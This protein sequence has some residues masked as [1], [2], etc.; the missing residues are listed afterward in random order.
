[1]DV[2]MFWFAMTSSL[3]S[4]STTDSI[5]LMFVGIGLICTPLAVLIYTRINTQRDAYE[6]SLATD[7]EK[8][9]ER[10]WRKYG[11]TP[12]ELREL[13]DRAPDFRYMLWMKYIISMLLANI[14]RFVMRIGVDVY[15]H[16]NTLFEINEVNQPQ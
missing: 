3:T 11:Y 7:M 16:D 10:K 8:F 6:A 12:Q 14:M 9:T 2:S 13:G 1:L 5:E 15:V 4:S